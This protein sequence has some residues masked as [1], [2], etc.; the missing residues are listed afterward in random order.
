[1]MA[2][3]RLDLS[4]VMDAHPSASSELV[5]LNVCWDKHV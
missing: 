3:D 5:S 1:M 4:V 2:L